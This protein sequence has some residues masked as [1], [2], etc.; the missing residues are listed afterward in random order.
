MNRVNN[1]PAD[2]FLRHIV[3]RDGYDLTEDQIQS[4]AADL[5]W[6]N[7]PKGYKAD[8]SGIV[9]KIDDESRRPAVRS[10]QAIC[11]EAAMSDKATSSEPPK[12]PH[13]RDIKRE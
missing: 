6:N 7:V 8:R 10:S 9:H 4:M 11:R 1:I 3:K 13:P 2:D 12:A 5:N